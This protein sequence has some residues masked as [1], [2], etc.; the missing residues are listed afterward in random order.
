MIALISNVY[1]LKCR[2]FVKQPFN[3][4]LFG[5]LFRRCY[6]IA[7]D[8]ENDSIKYVK[9]RT[10]MNSMIEDEMVNYACKSHIKMRSFN[11]ISLEMKS[12]MKK[13]EREKRQ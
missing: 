8:D 2:R 10:H 4:Y 1:I 12:Q 3:V 7:L 11:S 9:V 5:S 13:K 6:L